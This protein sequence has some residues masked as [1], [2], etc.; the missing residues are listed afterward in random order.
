MRKCESKISYTRNRSARAPFYNNAPPVCQGLPQ[1]NCQQTSNGMVILR[2]LVMACEI[3]QTEGTPMRP[4]SP[5]GCAKAF[6]TQLAQVYRESYGLFVCNGILYNHESLRRGENFVTR[7]IRA[8]L[9]GSHGIWRQSWCSGI[10]RAKEIGVVL[11]TMSRR[12]G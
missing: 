11:R 2:E 9:R 7:K 4:T 3:P 1:P 12:C 5:Y 6:A 8:R 10:L